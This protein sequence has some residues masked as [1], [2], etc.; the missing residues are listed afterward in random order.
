MKQTVLVTGASSGI[1]Y[2]IAKNLIDSNYEVFGSSRKLPKGPYNWTHLSCDLK[3]KSSIH[4]LCEILNKQISKLDILINCAGYG[5]GNAVEYTSYEDA[6]ELY[7]VNVLGTFEITKKLLPLLRKS[8]KPK[9][10]NI[11]SVAGEITIPFQCFYS[12]SKSDLTVL[13][14]ALRIELKPFNIDVSI[15]LPGDIKTN[16]T[17]NRIVCLDFDEQ[18]KNRIRLSLEKMAKDEQNGMDVESVV[19]VVKKQIKRTKMKPKVAVGYQ[20]KAFLF[21]NRY[22]PTKIKEFIIYRLYA[23]GKN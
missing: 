16:F 9:I 19:N 1:G 3:D 10:I 23:N 6:L 7:Q 13:T 11:G 22:L 15:I 18:Y 20:Y 21:L 5:I 4:Q 2:S 8:Q 12:M 17:A 14:E